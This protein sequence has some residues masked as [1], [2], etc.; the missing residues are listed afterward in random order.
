[1]GWDDGME[2]FEKVMLALVAYLPVPFWRFH[3]E[4]LLNNDISL[5]K[6]TR[7]KQFDT[8]C[9]LR[10]SIPHLKRSFFLQ[11]RSFSIL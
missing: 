5:V 11:Q 2:M 6:R 7:K 4:I 3:V 1:M 9:T 10:N 8:F